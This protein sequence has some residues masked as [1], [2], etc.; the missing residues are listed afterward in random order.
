VKNIDFSRASI[1]TIV[2]PSPIEES[3]MN[4]RKPIVIAFFVVISIVSVSTGHA[5]A[6][7][8]AS[9]ESQEPALTLM[10]E[11]DPATFAFSGYAAHVRVATAYLPGLVLGVGFYG[12]SVPSIMAE[13]HPSNRDKGWDV[14]LKNGYGLF[15]DYHFSGKPSG[16]FVGLQLAVQRWLLRRDRYENAEEYGTLLA[17]ARVGTL[18]QPF[19]TAGF[20]IM[21]WVGVGATGKIF[22]KNSIGDRA[23]KVFPVTAFGALHVGWKF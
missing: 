2:T 11:T 15:A 1:S 16:L 10:V 6:A 12:M 22:G 18:W 14:E 3:V 9:S 21:P 17:M 19:K 20:Y 4:I 7:P 5:R 8:S 23:Y 13:I